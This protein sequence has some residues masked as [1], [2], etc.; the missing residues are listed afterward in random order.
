MATMTVDPVLA[1]IA[2]AVALHTAGARAA[3]HA[4]LVAIWDE[5][6][7][8]GD[9]LHRCAVAHAMA[10]VVDD[11]HEQLRWDLRALAAAD[12]VTDDRAAHA[13]IATP[14]AAFYPSLHLNLG[15]AYRRTGDLARAHEHLERGR[16]ALVHLAG[17]G[18]AEMLRDAFAR[19]ADR[20]GS[21]TRGG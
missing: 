3:A 10:D 8:D 15:E 2:E 6:G 14:I 17:D 9:P 5:L 13:G 16:A 7:R 12:Q 20:L 11:P 1:R 4:Q 18:S 19:L 21:I